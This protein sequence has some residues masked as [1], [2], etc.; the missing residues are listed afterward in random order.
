MDSRKK[1]D[2]VKGECIFIKPNYCNYNKK[3]DYRYFIKFK[4]YCKKSILEKEIEYFING[5]GI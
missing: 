2:V 4:P 1:D 3:C 5:S